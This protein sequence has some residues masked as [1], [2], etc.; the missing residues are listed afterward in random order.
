MHIG[1][2]RAN[3]YLFLKTYILTYVL[4]IWL[5][6]KIRLHSCPYLALIDINLILGGGCPPNLISYF[7]N[8][9]CFRD[10]I[11]DRRVYI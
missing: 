3:N 9:H 6:K 2:K 7:D 5:L 10:E 4:S 11:N 1:I 8:H